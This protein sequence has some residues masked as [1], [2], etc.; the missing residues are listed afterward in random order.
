MYAMCKKNFPGLILK[1]VRNRFFR[2]SVVALLYAAWAEWVGQHWLLLGIIII[3]DLYLTHFVNWRFWRK[4]L[5]DGEKQKIAAEIIDSLVIAMMLAVFIRLFVAQ[6]YTIPTS[7]MEKTL[8]VGDYILVSKLHAGPRLPMTPVTVPFTHNTLPFTENKKSFSTKYALPYKRLSGLSAIH[9]FDIVVFNYPIGDTVIEDQVDKNYYQMVRQYGYEYLRE[10]YRLIYRP[11]D[12]RDNYTKRVV[13]LPGDTIAI[14]HG[15]AYVNGIPEPLVE[16]SQFNYSLKAKG[17]AED[18]MLM[19]K[20]GVS[21]YDVNYN[22]YNSIYNLPLT[23]K[24]YHT[25]I[26]SGYFKAIVRYES[27]DPSSVN[28]QIFPQN[29]DFNWTEDNYGPLYVPEKG[30]A[31][32]LTIDNLPLYERIITAYEGNRLKLVNDSIYINNSLAS[33][34]TFKMD[35]YF[36]LGDNRHNSKDS[37]YWGFVP[38]DH[39]IGRAILIWFSADKKENFFRSIRWR[40]MLKRIR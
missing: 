29:S 8:T 11:V 25:L 10:N 28:R 16:G 37:R 22:V 15:R 23:R 18:T 7:S 19:K 35:Y 38:Q 30:A 6:A 2:F 4:R 12:K 24:M 33:S 26:D 13:G 5:P 34:Y 14:F 40:R 17:N 21:L 31:V 20:L 27:I 3:A 39:I 1:L 32:E 9:N 36:M